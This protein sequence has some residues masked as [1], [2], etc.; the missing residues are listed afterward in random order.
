MNMSEHRPPVQDGLP[1]YNESQANKPE[2][3]VPA[4][5]A[6]LNAPT[7]DKAVLAQR[8]QQQMQ[9]Q[10]QPT[11]VQMIAGPSGTQATQVYFYQDP[12]TGAR[13]TTLLPPDHP[14][15]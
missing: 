12:V 8:E 11:P 3:T 1:S 6:A 14:G 4:A 2:P 10:M 9:P 15:S 7:D 5:P 13:V